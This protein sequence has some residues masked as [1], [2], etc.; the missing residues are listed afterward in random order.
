MGRERVNPLWSP[1]ARGTA[2]GRGDGL[3]A[4]WSRVVARV[5]SLALRLAFTRG[6]GNEAPSSV[7]SLVAALQECR[8]VALV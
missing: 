6:Y 7:A 4:D 3:A 8:S 5:R 2:V 1:L